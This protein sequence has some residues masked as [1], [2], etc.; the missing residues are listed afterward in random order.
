LVVADERRAISPDAIGDSSKARWA[1]E[2]DC[3]CSTM[4]DPLSP[5]D[6]YPGNW[7]PIASLF[8]L[9]FLTLLVSSF[10]TALLSM[11]ATAFWL[12]KNQVIAGS[13]R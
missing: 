5:D 11:M 7:S 6:V 3:P 2:Q 10:F 13:Y 12:D 8:N 1:A 9:S 4:I